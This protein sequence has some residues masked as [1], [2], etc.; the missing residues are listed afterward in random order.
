[1]SVTT[2]VGMADGDGDVKFVDDAGP[3]AVQVER[4]LWLW[5]RCCGT[6]WV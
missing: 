4:G 2:G 3:K 5:D 1:M 6:G